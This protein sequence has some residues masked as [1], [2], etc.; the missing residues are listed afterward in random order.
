MRYVRI[1]TLIFLVSSLVGC[2]AYQYTTAKKESNEATKEQQEEVKTQVMKLLEEY[3]KQPF[4][5][6]S[7]DYSYE[8]TWED[9][10]CQMSFCKMIK[11]GIYKFKVEA[12]NNPII[13]FDFV[14]SENKKESIN[15]LI[16]SFK[17]NQL[18]GVYC[19]IGLD[20]YYSYL[21][22]NN[23]KA[24]QPNTDDTVKYC[25]SIGQTQYSLARDYYL[26]HESK[27]K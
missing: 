23:T 26:K 19:N 22:D 2:G 9:S 21:N 7:F 1:I 25:E 5:L 14:I 13:K 24:K 3:Y 18:K 8:R 12:I 11:Y 6:K 16:D 27:Y 17:K 15:S 10:S 20:N 4:E